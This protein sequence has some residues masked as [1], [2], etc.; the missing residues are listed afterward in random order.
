[1]AD[2]WPRKLFLCIN[3]LQMLAFV[4]VALVRGSGA[5]MAITLFLFGIVI[6][7]PNS[8]LVSRLL[9]GAAEAARTHVDLDVHR[10]QHRDRRRRCLARWPWSAGR[11]LTNFR[12]LASALVPLRRRFESSRSAWS[13]HFRS[14]ASF[15]R[16]L[17]EVAIQFLVGTRKLTRRRIMAA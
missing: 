3:P 11:V 8:T 2:R 5:T 14:S 4:V 13:G 1:M 7:L 17:S 15:E 10:L 12:G 6:F 16:S 9:K